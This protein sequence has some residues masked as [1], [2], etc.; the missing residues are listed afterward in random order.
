VAGIT[1]ALTHRRCVCCLVVKPHRARK[2]FERPSAIRSKEI[3]RAIIPVEVGRAAAGPAIQCHP[4]SA[5]R[6]PWRNFPPE[7]SIRLGKRPLAFTKQ[8][9][10]ERAQIGRDLWLKRQ[11]RRLDRVA[12]LGRER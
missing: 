1:D 7:S 3:G 11:R 9:V 8:C 5:Y 4:L 10:I 12:R 2:A 6:L